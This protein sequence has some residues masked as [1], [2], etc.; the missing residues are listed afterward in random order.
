MSTLANERLHSEQKPDEEANLRGRVEKLK[1][2]NGDLRALFALRLM[3]V[4]DLQEIADRLHDPNMDD[5]ER[6]GIE[7]AIRKVAATLESDIRD[8]DPEAADMISQMAREAMVLSGVEITFERQNH[9]NGDTSELLGMD[10][11]AAP[12]VP[13]AL[14]PRTQQGDT[15]ALYLG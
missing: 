9:P 1:E 11:S 13:S 6:A 10:M 12:S 5:D 3:Q 15:A 7:A 14:D 2:E 4:I 8:V